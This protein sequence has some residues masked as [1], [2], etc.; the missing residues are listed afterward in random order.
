MHETLNERHKEIEDIIGAFFLLT[1]LTMRRLGRTLQPFG[2]THPQLKVLSALYQHKE[3][4]AMGDLANISPF[5][6]GP[7]MT[8][9]VDRLVRQGLLKRWRSTTDRRVV[10]VQITQA[11]IEK[12]SRVREAML[13]VECSPFETVTDATM[14]EIKKHLDFLLRAEIERSP[15]MQGI[16]FDANPEGLEMFIRDPIAFVQRQNSGWR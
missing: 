14:I 9:V 15:L 3:A 4:C 1:W 13:S 5:Q 7:T 10:K 16:D 12:V 2:L 11:G 8:G 6:D